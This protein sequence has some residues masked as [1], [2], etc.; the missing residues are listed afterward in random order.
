MANELGAALGFAD[1]DPEKID[2]SEIRELTDSIP[3]DGN[4]DV[5]IAEVL[6]T[7]FLRGAD[8]CS[9]ILAQLTWWEARMDDEK[10][11]ALAH[12]SLVTAAAKGLKTATEK[13]TYADADPEY[14]KACE[15]AN[16]AKAMKQWFKNKHESFVSAHYLM[17]EIAKGGRSHLGA[18]GGS[19]S[20][21]EKGWE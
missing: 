15:T 19:S 3:K 8:R 5:V 14:L 4:V 1:F 9:E 11:R 2:V 10:R 13:R 17:K 12:A 20:W 18:G 7:R 6:A 16:R 21:G